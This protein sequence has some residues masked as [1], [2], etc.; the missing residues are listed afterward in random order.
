MGCY[1][2]CLSP[3]SC[4]AGAVHIAAIPGRHAGFQGDLRLAVIYTYRGY[5]V[6]RWT[7]LEM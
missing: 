3:R 7:L 5:I 6:T 1:E 2:P 4:Q